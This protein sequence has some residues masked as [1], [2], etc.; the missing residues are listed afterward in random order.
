MFFSVKLTNLKPLKLYSALLYNA[1]NSDDIK[2]TDD[3]NKEIHRFVFQT[4]RYENFEEQ[5]NSCILKD[6]EGNEQKAIFELLT[7]MPVESEADVYT[8]V[9]SP[10]S[11]ILPDLSIRYPHN[12]DKLIEGVF[13]FKPLEAAVTTE[14]NVIRNRATG[15]V[16]AILVRNPEPFNDPKIPLDQI[17]DTIVGTKNNIGFK[18]LYSKD[19]SQAIIVA[20]G[21]PITNGELL[22]RFQYKLWDGLG[23]NV[24]KTIPVS[25][26][27]NQ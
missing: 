25:I 27:I 24:K 2:L 15:N 12:F 18:T 6:D 9:W 13:R 1:F 26:T 19:Y 8:I 20:D 21:Y 3:H 10:H 11:D 14:F 22:I 7:D 4:S 17:A 16:I 23:Y 5:V